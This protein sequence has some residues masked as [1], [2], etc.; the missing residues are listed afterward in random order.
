[1]RRRALLSGSG[2][3]AAIAATPLR[4]ALAQPAIAPRAQILRFAPHASLTFLD[5][6]ANLTAITN[7]HGFYVFDTLY[8][9]DSSLRPRPQMAEGHAVSDDGLT[10]SIRLRDGL[11][12]H[13]GSPVLARDCV[14]SLRRWAAR[15]TFGRDLATVVEDWGTADDRTIR[16]QLKRPFPLLIE[17][18][19]KPTASLPVIMPERLANTDP[20]KALTEMVGSG[21]LR[22]KAD[23]FVSGS[24]VVYERFGGYQ[25]RQEAPDFF[26]GGKVMHFD[27]VEWTIMPDQATGLAALQTGEI[28]WLDQVQADLLPL[29]SRNRDVVTD[30]LD[31]AGFMGVIRFNA[32]QPPFDRSEIRRIVLQSVTQPNYMN[33][34][35]G[36]DATAWR[37]CHSL[38]PCGTPYGTPPTDAGMSDTP[39]IAAKKRALSA[40][41]YNGEKVVIMNPSDV[42]IIA[43]F[44]HV[45]HDLLRQLGMNVELQE[46]DWGSLISRAV[47]RETPDKGGWSLYHTWWGGAGIAVPVTNA[48]IRGLGDRGWTGWYSSERMEELNADWLRVP[49]EAGRAVIAAEMNALAMRDAPTVPLGIFSVRTAYRKS[50]TGM[51]KALRPVPWNVRR[52]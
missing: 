51:L 41:G 5:P 33:L 30:I 50:L 36:G 7:I 10:W 38:F 18:I 49:D 37:S 39:D 9:V 17:A 32:L 45:T 44:G 3:V 12:F 1:M 29:V 35:T 43:P 48:L 34:V 24:K 4:A 23:E 46:M 47:S 28:D 2:A 26:S 16:I 52:A 20:M 25:P 14:A 8:A 15:D 6:V 31:P 19:G 42:P 22:F 21:P 40:A 13:D 27:R 11:K